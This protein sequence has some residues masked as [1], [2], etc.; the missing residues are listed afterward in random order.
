MPEISNKEI[1][2]RLNVL[3]KLMELH[4]MDEV[5]ARKYQS[6]AYNLD[7]SGTDIVEM[8]NDELKKI[9]G[10]NKLVLTKIQ[11][12]KDTGELQA[13]NNLIE[14]TPSGLFQLINVKGLGPKKIGSLWRELGIETIDDLKKAC[15]TN[16]VAGLKG[17]GAKTQE[18][19]VKQIEFL[20]S[21][22]SQSRYAS[23]EDEIHKW[24]DWLKFELKSEEFYITGEAYR[25]DQVISLLEYVVSEYDLN[26][27]KG[28]SPLKYVQT[29]IDEA[30]LEFFNGVL[31]V[32]VYGYPKNLLLW[33]QFD[34]SL[35]EGHR[36]YLVGNGWKEKPIEIANDADVYSELNLPYTV[37]E[38]RVGHHEHEWAQKYN[39]NDL[40]EWNDE[41]IKAN[42]STFFKGMI[43][44]HSKYSDGYNSIREMA[45]ECMK[46]G[47]EYMV[48]SDHS[49]S[50]YYAGGMKLDKLQKQFAEIDALNQEY[51]GKF[52]IFKSVESDILSSGSLDYPNDMLAQFDLVIASIHAGQ[53]M[54]E[55][56]ATRRLLTA[57]ENPYT[58]V[59]GHPTG[60]QLLIRPGYPVNHKKIIAACASNKVVIEINANPRRLDIDWTWVYYAMEKGCMLAINPDAHSTDGL[61]DIKYGTY[62]ARKGGLVKQHLLNALS[63]S[64]FEK[65]L[66]NQRKKRQ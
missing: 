38:M 8:P 55:D 7:K 12:L 5:E 37:P 1:T 58:T 22:A 36:D 59:L 46:M 48:M 32:R 49:Q 2:L 17:F 34:L 61:Y 28:H 44:M 25:Y 64:E 33:H 62:V 19:I 27:L 29:E 42:T 63:L 51:K 54:D 40:V 16:T 43:H 14:Q 4:N 20:E 15:A 47:A 56:T 3:G 39:L 31:K 45:E 66:V 21:G 60:R 41:D 10:V 52:K 6:A 30:T 23:V 50:A 11:E 18:N 24:N 9:P 26:K 35:T 53:K 57:I 13:L 65:F